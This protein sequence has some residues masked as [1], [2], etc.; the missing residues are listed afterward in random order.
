MENKKR[1]KEPTI[2]AV[3]RMGVMDIITGARPSVFE[4]SRSRGRLSLLGT[5][6]VRVRASSARGAASG[7]GSSHGGIIRTLTWIVALGGR[8]CRGLCRSSEVFRGSARA[9]RRRVRV[10]GRGNRPVDGGHVR[11]LIRFECREGERA[12]SRM[13]LEELFDWGMADTSECAAQ[14]LERLERALTLG[15]IALV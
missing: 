7:R 1:Q 13:V 4:R 14:R 12:R 15:K 8:V 9:R 3:V 5:L 2:E 10:L 11:V 6:V